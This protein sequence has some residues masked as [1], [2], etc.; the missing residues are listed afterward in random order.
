MQGWS[1]FYVEKW[2]FFMNCDGREKGS[3]RKTK[4]NAGNTNLGNHQP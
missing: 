4:R 3:P 2:Q 1:M